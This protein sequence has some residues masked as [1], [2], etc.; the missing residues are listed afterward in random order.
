MRADVSFVCLVRPFVGLVQSGAD[1]LEL[2]RL[3]PFCPEF[4][5]SCITRPSSPF[6]SSRAQLR[7]SMPQIRDIH[8]LRAR[9][10]QRNSITAGIDGERCAKAWLERNGW[11]FICIDDQGRGT[12]SDQLKSYGGKRPDFLAHVGHDETIVALDAKHVST[13][14]CQTFAMT[15]AELAKYR[16]LEQFLL[17]V[18]G[19]GEVEVVF[20]VIPKERNCTRMTSSA[21]SSSPMVPQ[22]QF[23]TSQRLQ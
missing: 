13:D 7:I 20:M 3:A 21:S 1:K 22:R 11:K 2:K 5:E 16:G 19:G 17:S 8:E 10:R 23:T 18:G 6:S 9:L 12:M 4:G 15:D 14:D